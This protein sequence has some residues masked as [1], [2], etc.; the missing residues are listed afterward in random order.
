VA[1]P[2]LFQ[3]KLLRPLN[4][5]QCV[6]VDEAHNYR[7]PDTRAR[8]AV[9]RKLLWGQRRDVLL[10]TATP[11][12]NSLWD[13]FHLLRF[14]VR[15]D[16]F[17]ANRGILSIRER[18]EQA[19]RE[20]P[21][22]LSPDMLYPIIDATTVKRTRQFVKKHYSGDQI[23]LPD[24]RVAPIVFPIPQA[25]TVRYALPDPMPDLFDLLEGALDPDQGQD[26]ISFARYTPD[27]YLREEGNDDLS[28]EQARAAATVGLLRSGLLKRFE[29]SAFA[30]GRTLDKL[31]REHQMFLEAVD[32]GM[33]SRRASCAN[34]PR[35]TKP[36]S[37]ICWL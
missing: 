34:W 27:L 5:Y 7:N 36:R 17:L 33:W 9:L 22:A 18:F 12:N 25:I 24:G 16:A 2:D 29:S 30:F 1:E 37:T 19:A 32:R 28:E 11:V 15:Q 21:A 8:A 3:D 20:D 6:V 4:E 14:F 35:R 10:L 26:S 23:T 31:I 13:L